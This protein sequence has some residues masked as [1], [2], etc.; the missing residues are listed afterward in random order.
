M[1]INITWF[2]SETKVKK[3]RMGIFFSKKIV[4]SKKHTTFVA[5]FFEKFHLRRAHADVAQSARAA[6]L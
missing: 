6:D 3:M 2:K 1:I 4:N 5:S